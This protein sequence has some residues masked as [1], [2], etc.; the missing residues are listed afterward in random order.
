ME[1]SELSEPWCLF[2]VLAQSIKKQVVMRAAC[3]LHSV[4]EEAG[5]REDFGAQGLDARG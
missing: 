1:S 2:L 5:L 3:C 4:G